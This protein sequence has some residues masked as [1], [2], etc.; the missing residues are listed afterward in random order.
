[1]P[2][3]TDQLP[4]FK[5]KKIEPSIWALQSFLHYAVG[6]GRTHTPVKELDFESSASANSATTACLFNYPAII[7]LPT[8]LAGFEPAHDGTKNRCLTAWL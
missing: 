7:L 3:N 8:G 2:V 5:R 6:G 4:S 1:M